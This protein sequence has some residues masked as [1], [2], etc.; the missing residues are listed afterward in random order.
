MEKMENV[1]IEWFGCGND[2]EYKVGERVEYLWEDIEY[3]DR[4]NYD[5]EFVDEWVDLKNRLKNGNIV[6]DEWDEI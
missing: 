3:S 5:D 1:L 2:N 4:D 6:N